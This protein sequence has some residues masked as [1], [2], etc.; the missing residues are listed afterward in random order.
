MSDYIK[1]INEY[2]GVLEKYAG[3]M[4]I[5]EK[6]LPYKKDDIKKAIKITLAQWQARIRKKNY[7]IFFSY[8]G[9]VSKAITCRS[10]FEENGIVL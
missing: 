5:N 10:S 8:S 6:H 7:P 4:V 9:I 3:Y 2:G 1:I